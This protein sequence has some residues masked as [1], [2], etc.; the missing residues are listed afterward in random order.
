[1]VAGGV[2]LLLPAGAA[3]LTSILGAN[4]A[5]IGVAMV[6]VTAIT[7]TVQYLWVQTKTGIGQ[8][9][10]LAIAASCAANVGLFS[11]ATAGYVDDAYVAGMLIPG[12]YINTAAAG[13]SAEINTTAILNF[14]YLQIAFITS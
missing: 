6:A 13:A 11:T 10:K 8:T 5:R 2:I 7:S 9:S 12:M 1:M 3:S 14:P 4:K